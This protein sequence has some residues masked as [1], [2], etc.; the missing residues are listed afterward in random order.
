MNSS[1]GIVCEGVEEAYQ[2]DVLEKMNVNYIQG[3]LHSK[4]IPEE[5]FIEFL[6]KNN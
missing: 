1:S 4:P 2:Q 5:E 3:F 6:K